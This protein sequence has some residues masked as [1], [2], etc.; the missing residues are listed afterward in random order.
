LPPI[1]ATHVHHTRKAVAAA[2]HMLVHGAASAAGTDLYRLHARVKLEDGSVLPS[3]HAALQ[4]FAVKDDKLDLDPQC[5]FDF[6]VGMTVSLPNNNEHIAMGIANGTTA[7]IV[8]VVPPLAS[9][10][11]TVVT[12]TTPGGSKH[13]VHV[14]THQPAAI[15]VYNPNFDV[16]FEDYPRGVMP[17]TPVTK[18]INQLPACFMGAKVT[19]LPLRH[20]FARTC[21]VLQ[22]ATL[23][24]MVLGAICTS[25]PGWLYTAMSRV[26]S[27]SALYL[28]DGLNLTNFMKSGKNACPDKAADVHRLQALSQTSF[29]RVITTP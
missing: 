26:G 3:T 4:G 17:I 19:Y 9:A 7:R 5:S 8:G 14:L 29:A 23:T 20:T 2:N 22:G 11:K 6:F 12:H 27:W 28:Y 25:I 18:Q 16:H 24:A 15:L 10:K 1:H 21:H 13:T